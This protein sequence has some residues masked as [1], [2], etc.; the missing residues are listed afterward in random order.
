[1]PLYFAYGANMDVDGMAARCPSSKA[2][3]LARLPRHRPAIMREG[4]LTVVRDISADAHGVLWDLALSDVAALDRFEDVSTRLYTKIVQPVLTAGGS[5]RALVY[6][7]ANSGPGKADAEYIAGVLVTAR[8]WRLPAEGIAAYERLAREAG[9][10]VEAP[11]STPALPKV[12]PRL[13]TP[14]ER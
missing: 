9:V 6:V 14:M 12:R 8:R 13:A 7:G 5:R 2:L 1:M 4:W 11:V 3:G 10:K